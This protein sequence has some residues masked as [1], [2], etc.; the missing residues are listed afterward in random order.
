MS[1]I[2]GIIHFDG[3][4]VERA[5]L[6]RMSR[7]LEPFG[8]DGARLGGDDGAGFVVRSTILT[9]E[10]R[11]ERQPVVLDDGGLFVFG[12]R[13]DN[14]PD[15]L[16]RL[17]LGEREGRTLADGALAARAW[18][19]WGRD[20]LVSLIGMFAAAHWN[21]QDRRLT[22]ARSSPRG[23]GLFV[24]RQGDRLYFASSPH[25]LFALPQVP[26]ALNEAV[27]GDV[28]LMNTSDGDTLYEGITVVRNSHWVEY[29]RDGEES[30]RYWAPDPAYRLAFRREEEAWEA[31]RP[32]FAEVVG[33]HLRSAHPVGMQMSG[34]LDSAAVAGQAALLLAGRG[35]TLNGYTRVPAPGTPLRPDGMFYNDERPRVERIAAMHPNLRP[36]FVHAGDEPVLEGLPGHFAAVQGFIGFSPTFMTGYDVLYRRA[37]DDGVRVLLTGASGNGTFSYDGHARLRALLLSGRWPTL[38]RELVVLK[39]RRGGVRELVRRELIESLVP[40]R[41]H[42]VALR[43]R[44]DGAEPWSDY[45]VASRAFIERNGALERARERANIKLHWCHLDSWNRRA[46]LFGRTGWVGPDALLARFGLDTRDPSGD[47]RLIEFCLALPDEF[48]LKDGVTRRFARLGLA[49]LIPDTVRHDRTRGRQDVDWAYRIKRDAEAVARALEQLENDPTIG[50]TLDVPAMRSMWERFHSIDWRHASIGDVVRYDQGLMRG[51]AIGRFLR[52]FNGNN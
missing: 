40:H 31:F 33:A 14:R 29:R 32:L 13:L 46:S 5:E 26:R 3:E 36:H 10:D 28:L 18:Q 23:K 2:A 21:P 7:A 15:L 49:H 6:E 51:V 1:A 9:P 35:R 50:A 12:G 17:G 47:R 30:R 41:L 16:S 4:P 19:R 39:R 25:G 34:G 52:W 24:H 8:R 37:A 27:L 22:L 44:N 43:L 20:G 48:Y 42:R 11:L 45:S 38:L